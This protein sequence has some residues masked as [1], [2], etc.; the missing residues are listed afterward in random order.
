MGIK[1]SIFKNIK[2]INIHT[3]KYR[4]TSTSPFIFIAILSSLEIHARLGSILLG[5]K[6][7]IYTFFKDFSGIITK[8]SS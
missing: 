6:P 8:D 3:A 4:I 1:I 5:S 7:Q 2:H